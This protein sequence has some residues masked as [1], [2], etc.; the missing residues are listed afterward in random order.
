MKDVEKQYVDELNCLKVNLTSAEEI[1]NHNRAEIAELRALDADKQKKIEYL[2]IAN[3]ELR[4]AN[5]EQ[6]DRIIVLE[7]QN[8]VHRNDFEM[9]RQ[10]RETAVGEKHQILQDLRALQKKNQDLIE[11][12]QKLVQN[13]EKRMSSS[14]SLAGHPSFTAA[15][16]AAQTYVNNPQRPIRVC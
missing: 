4:A 15:A 10:S 13:Y 11:E 9:E 14:S 2:E 16:A 8:Q 5:L 1:I 6:N 3:S 12:R 7:Q